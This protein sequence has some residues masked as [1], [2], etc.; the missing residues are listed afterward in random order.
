M[1]VFSISTGELLGSIE[2][3]CHCPIFTG[4][5]FDILDATG[6]LVFIIKCPVCTAPCFSNVVFNVILQQLLN[7]AELFI[8]KC[9]CFLIRWFRLWINKLQLE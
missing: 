3:R 1:S 6:N 9:Q 2:Q 5:K 4:A 7:H 8:F